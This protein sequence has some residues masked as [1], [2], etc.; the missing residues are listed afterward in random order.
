M[1][2]VPRAAPAIAKEVGNRAGEGRA[3]A[4]LGNA[5]K[6]QRDY[7][8]TIEHH[9]QYLAIA[10]EVGDRER[11]LRTPLVRLPQHRV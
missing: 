4:N 3:H 8:K 10:Q 9:T 7:A 6:S 1:N 2:Q 5:Y 11:A